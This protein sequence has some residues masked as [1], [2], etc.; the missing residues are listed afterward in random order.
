MILQRILARR[1]VLA[2]KEYPLTLVSVSRNDQGQH[3]VTLTPFER[4]TANTVY[5]PGTLTIASA[6]GS[7]WHDGGSQPPVLQME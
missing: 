1:V 3:T 2:G 6:D 5:H 7:D 4:E